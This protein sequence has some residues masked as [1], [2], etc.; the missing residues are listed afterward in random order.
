GFVT[1]M[2]IKVFDPFYRSY[3]LKKDPAL[4]YKAVFAPRV[5]FKFYP[6]WN[7]FDSQN[8]A[9]GLFLKTNCGQADFVEYSLS[10]T[11]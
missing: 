5:G 10:Y 4:W 7:S 1:D 6:I 8:I 11:F 3:F 2:G 9:I